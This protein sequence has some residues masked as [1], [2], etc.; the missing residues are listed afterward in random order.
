MSLTFHLLKK[1][2]KKIGL[3]IND[4][5]NISEKVII[6]A[7]L[8]ASLGDTSVISQN[9]HD[10][11]ISIGA[12]SYIRSG[13]IEGITDIG[14]FCSFGQN[15]TIGQSKKTHPIDWASTS[16]TL[17]TDHTLSS[18]RTAIGHDVWIGDDAVIMEGVTIGQG[19]IIG[20]RALV[21]K[22]VEPYQIVAG[23]P[24]KPVR[25]RFDEQLRKGLLESNWWALDLSQLKKTDYKN[26]TEFIDSVRTINKPAEYKKVIVTRESIRPAES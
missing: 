20:K 24:A 13:T 15:V 26:V 12:H 25:Y 2:A 22:D 3:K 6:H 21:T 7:E 16:H 1:K 8:P 9:N 18:E 19:A 14:R 5:S 23:N 11:E 17:C 4:F 10:S